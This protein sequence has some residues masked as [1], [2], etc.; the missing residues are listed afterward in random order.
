MSGSGA[1]R[2]RL[3][4]LTQWFEPEPTFKGHGFAKSLQERGFDVDV[5]TGFPN[6]PSGRLHPGYK[7]RPIKREVMDGIRLTRVPLYPSH[8]NSGIKRSLNYL[9]FF[10]SA[11]LYLLFRRR[12][13]D[14]IYIY[15]PPITSGLAPAVAG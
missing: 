13:Y 11:C 3:L 12:R 14:V 8:D 1:R 6:F 9:S 7:I 10:V 15:H 2:P 5:L 4:Y